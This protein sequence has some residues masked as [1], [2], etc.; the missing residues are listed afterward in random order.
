MPLDATDRSPT[1]TASWL[2]TVLGSGITTELF[3]RN[4]DDFRSRLREV[5]FEA[6][7]FAVANAGPDVARAGVIEL[8]RCWVACVGPGAPH[9]FAAW[10][11]LGAE[12]AQAGD[13]RGAMLAYQSALAAWP[14]FGTAAIK[15]A[16]LLEAD[17][18][19][20]EAITVL[21]SALQSDDARIALINQ[22][23]RL[24]EQKKRLQEAEQELQISLLIRPDQPDVIQHWLHIRQKQCH[25]GMLSDAVPGLSRDSL[26]QHSGPLSALALFDDV[27][28]Q[29][30][31]NDVWI[32][33]KMA[34]VDE[35]LSP[36]SGY[37]HDRI[38]LG[39]MSSDFCQHAMSLL[40][41]ELFERHDRDKFEVFGYCAS[42]ED[43]SDTRRR[44]IAA[45]DHFTR[46]V[47][48]SDEQA[49]RMIRADEIDILIDLNGL[50]SGTR[51]QA[52]RWRP[53]PVQAT[54]LGFVGPVPLPELD[55][56]FCD[57]I[58]VPPEIAAE[59]R[60]TPLYVA[61]FYQANDSKRGRP[62]PR[63]RAQLGLPDDG[64]VFCCFS[65]HYKITEKMFVAWMAILG[66]VDSSVL[67]LID[68][69]VWSSAHFADAARNA[70]IDP[71]RIVSASRTS[72]LEYL[73]YLGAADLFLDTYP[74]NAGTIASDAIRMHLPLVTLSGQSFASRMAGRLLAAL[75]AQ[76][77]VA[78]SVDDYVEKAVALATDRNRYDAYKLRFTDDAWAATIGNIAKFTEQFERSLMSI[79]VRPPPVQ[80]PNDTMARSADETA[81]TTEVPAQ[82]NMPEQKSVD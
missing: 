71:S 53:A 82:Q 25:W 2:T 76:E 10:Y 56:M 31:I 9:L 77:G 33:R 24:L 51:L 7:I 30:T 27:A 78:A 79:V 1:S 73:A 72:P 60:P 40:I 28:Q 68:D 19:L 26:V 36:P 12:L 42:P 44:V 59:Y 29:R 11:N 14:N 74:Y 75:G 3:N 67:W 34:P 45:F 62:V 81:V 64:F 23:G 47:D 4:D 21:D 48:L 58:V 37:R 16:Q 32:Q 5:T 41:A 22:R 6:L 18:C 49:A 69:N 35:R 52:L 43:G 80:Y 70:G 39:Y 13:G 15:L 38:R 57:S 46:I 66:R 8:Y 65:N 54:Y 50:T 61:E 63:S 20:S 17:G 55:Y